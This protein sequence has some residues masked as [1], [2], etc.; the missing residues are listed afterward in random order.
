MQKALNL[1]VFKI[2]WNCLTCGRNII[3]IRKTRRKVIQILKIRSNV[4]RIR[5]RIFGFASPA[6]FRR[7]YK[8]KVAKE[9]LEQIA[10]TL[11]S[12]HGN[13]SSK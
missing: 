6:I 4:I 13:T 12:S 2:N 8:A 10:S 3:G 1:G 9:I 7:V 5:P 11:W